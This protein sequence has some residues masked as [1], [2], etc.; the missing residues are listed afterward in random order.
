MQFI[1]DEDKNRINKAK[2][3]ISFETAKRVWDD[4][5]VW[6]YFDRFENGENR[7]HAVGVVGGMT[8][9]TVVHTHRDNAGMEIVRI[10]GA[11]RATRYEK[12]AYE[13]G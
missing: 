5:H 2:H 8:F 13:N 4:P 3:G 12:S 10:I 7:F 6:I 1:W 9:L 11:R